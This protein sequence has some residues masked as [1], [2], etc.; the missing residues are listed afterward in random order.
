MAEEDDVRL[1]TVLKRIE[2]TKQILVNLSS[3][4]YK[5]NSGKTKETIQSEIVEI[6]KL[7]KFHLKAKHYLKG[8]DFS[9]N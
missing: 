4:E 3:L 9:E 2:E 7:F 6:T 1:Q 8:E 5:L